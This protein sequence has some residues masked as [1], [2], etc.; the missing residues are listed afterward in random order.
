MDK[1]DPM[2]GVFNAPIFTGV[3]FL[4]HLQSKLERESLWFLY[5]R[6]PFHSEIFILLG[7]SHF[8]VLRIV[9]SPR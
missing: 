7:N 4:P 1:I 2:S 8:W 9:A 5:P 6:V 3:V